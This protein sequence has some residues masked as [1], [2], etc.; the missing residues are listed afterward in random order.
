MHF[1]RN[2][3]GRRDA[4]LRKYPVARGL[5]GVNPMEMETRAKHKGQ[6]K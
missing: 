4:N 6:V 2:L 5:E 1:L 3:T